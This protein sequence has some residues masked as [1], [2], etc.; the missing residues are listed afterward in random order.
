MKSSSRKPTPIT[1]TYTVNGKRVTQ[2]ESQAKEAAVKANTTLKSILKD[3]IKPSIQK[4]VTPATRINTTRLNLQTKV[5]KLVDTF[6]VVSGSLAERIKGICPESTKKVDT[7]FGGTSSF[8]HYLIKN[9]SL[10]SKLIN[11]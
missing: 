2:T 1:Y 6:K 7:T 3:V 10:S 5:N 11:V 4:T 9:S 8:A